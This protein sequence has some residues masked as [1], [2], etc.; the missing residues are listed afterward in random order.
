M[1]DFALNVDQELINLFWFS[2]LFSIYS[3]VILGNLDKCREGASIHAKSSFSL[4]GMLRKGDNRI[5]NL[6]DLLL[7]LSAT[8][9]TDTIYYCC[10]MI[11]GDKKI[12]PYFERGTY[13][14]QFS[15]LIM[16]LCLTYQLI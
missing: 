14:G 15:W 1:G 4:Q 6:E 13:K 11:F 16:R 9:T 3:G 5:S 10:K 7:S 8:E 2:L 12:L